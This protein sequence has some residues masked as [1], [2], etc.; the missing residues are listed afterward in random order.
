MILGV[1]EA[2]LSCLDMLPI[3]SDKLQAAVGSWPYL[4]SDGPMASLGPPNCW[5]LP[6]ESYRYDDEVVV[7][8]TPS[9]HRYAVYRPPG[10]KSLLGR[11]LCP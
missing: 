8:L 9:I 3:G 2:Y 1:R 10:F 5:Q 11:S 7:S 6:G 4:G